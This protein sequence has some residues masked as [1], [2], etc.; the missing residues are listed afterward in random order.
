MAQTFFPY[1]DLSVVS[2]LFIGRL[3][4]YQQWLY[5]SGGHANLRPF[6]FDDFCGFAAYVLAQ[7]EASGDASGVSDA[8]TY[9][10]C[11]STYLSS[12]HTVLTY[13]IKNFGVTYFNVDLSGST[14][15]YYPYFVNA[16]YY[17][18]RFYPQS[19]GSSGGGGGGSSDWTDTRIVDLLNAIGDLN[20]INERP[21]YVSGPPD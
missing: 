12:N 17:Y 10:S 8:A 1:F 11:L 20:V 19:S 6:L 3:G 21:I 14:G 4:I 13:F 5:P 18:L 7:F 2:R 9:V 16:V 15:T